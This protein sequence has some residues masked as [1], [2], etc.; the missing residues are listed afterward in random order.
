MKTCLISFILQHFFKK[1]KVWIFIGSTR[2][3]FDI[4]HTSP[5]K[6]AKGI[7]IASRGDK[8]S[9]QGLVILNF[10]FILTKLDARGGRLI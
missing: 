4:F 7:D 10:R 2:V 5:P 8:I 3:F 6:C 9:L 1:S